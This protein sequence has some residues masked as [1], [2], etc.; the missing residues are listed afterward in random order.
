MHSLDDFRTTPNVLSD[1]Y[2]H[3]SVAHR[4]LLTGHIHQS[5]PDVCEEAYKEHWDALNKRGE[6]RWD[7]VFDRFSRVQAGFARMI[8]ADPNNLALGASV[9]DLFVRFLSAVPLGEGTEIVTTDAEHPSIARQLARFHEEGRIKV[10]KVAAEPVESAVER[11]IAAVNDKTVAVC[12]SSVNF[13]N[14]QQVLELDTLPPVCEKY[15]AELFVDA[16][17][18]VNVQQFS[19][20]DYNLKQAFVVGGGAK[21]CQ[22]GNGLCFM[23]VPSH[24][25]YRPQVTGWFGAF[26]PVLDEP[27]AE[28]LVYPKGAARFNGSSNDALPLFRACKTLEFFE[29]QQL[30]VDLLFDINHHQLDFLAKGFKDLGVD[31]SVVEL[32]VD[33]EYMG[34]FLG[35]RSPH[36]QKI[37]EHMRDIGIH[38][39]HRHG[40]LR[41]GPA[42]YVCDE[43]LSDALLAME[44]SIAKL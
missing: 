11:V 36:A 23:H 31:P 39:D 38:T 7:I 29:Q 40:W 32:P 4:I 18:S 8:E 16:Y 6:E 41:L 21:Y 43:Q 26:D 12:V 3:A 9:H 44:E 22:M 15:G 35:L 10:I 14:G 25:D 5:L 19:I 37:S 24:R 17:L 33:V 20:E 13:E 27:A 28:P 42:P 2:R 1:H 34:G 30:D